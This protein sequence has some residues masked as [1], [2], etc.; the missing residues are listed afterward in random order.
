MRNA[1]L[2][3]LGLPM[4]SMSFD[5]LNDPRFD[6]ALMMARRVTGQAGLLLDIIVVPDDG[7][8]WSRTNAWQ[9]QLY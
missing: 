2:R 5:E 9:I 8:S 4:G 7:L 3:R 6:C 1:Q